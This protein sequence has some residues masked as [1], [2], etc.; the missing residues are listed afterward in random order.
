MPPQAHPSPQAGTPAQHAAE[1]KVATPQTVQA[2]PR[3]V[4]A[5]AVPPSHASPV[6]ASPSVKKKAVENGAP[7]STPVGTPA[8][9]APTPTQTMGSPQTP[10]SPKT[11]PSTKPKPTPKRK[12]SIKAG[13][14]SAPAPPPPPAAPAP[15]PATVSSPAAS[16]LE[17]SNKRRREDE[18]PVAPAPL[19]QAPSPKKQRTDW[20]G[21][22]SEELAKKKQ[23]V[24][25]IHTEEDATKFFEQTMSDLI[26]MASEGQD[27]PSEIAGALDQILKGYG[28][29][30]DGDAG[31]GSFGE[32]SAMRASSP[33][34]G[35][36]GLDGLE[37]FDFS[38][39]G[40][41][42][43]ETGSKAPTPDLLPAAIT[44][45][46]PESGSEMDHPAS[47]SHDSARIAEVKE[48]VPDSLR[49][50][51]WAQIDGGEAP[52]F[53][54]ADSNFKWDGPMTSFDPAWA[55]T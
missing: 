43:E 15:A 50:G 12:P 37:F 55:F 16:T 35:T 1:V 21:P 39:F 19:E 25:S 2:S 40:A 41:M 31:P 44:G 47:S 27:V 24:E 46:S 28:S 36:S 17:T 4:P 42:E 23:E 13:Q 22:V 52:Y 7:G 38:S 10:K 18:P 29:S 26:K 32:G 3:T 5:Q 51:V 9:S 45:P 14:T 54:G 33:A 6:M 34:A 48:E 8:A 53:Q 11:K 49:L 30:S 20:D